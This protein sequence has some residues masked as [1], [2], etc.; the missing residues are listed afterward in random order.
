MFL[1]VE[2][3]APTAQRVARVLRPFG[4][5]EIATTA[6]EGYRAGTKP[7]LGMVLDYILPGGTGIDVLRRAR[8]TN[9]TAVAL[10][11]TEYDDREIFTAGIELNASFVPKPFRLEDLYAFAGRALVAADKGDV[12]DAVVNELRGL[13]LTDA[14]LEDLR[15]AVAGHERDAICR[16]RNISPGTLQTQVHAICQKTGERELSSVVASV[17]RKAYVVVAARLD[18]RPDPPV[19][20]RSSR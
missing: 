9:P 19:E 16:F 12:I 11:L 4:G 20:R 14:E 6:D 13:N 17:L 15:L 1:V 3:H 5:V 8:V 7:W 2:D 10:L 18:Q